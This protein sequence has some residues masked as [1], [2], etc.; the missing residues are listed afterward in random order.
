MRSAPCRFTFTA[1]VAVS[2][3]SF[4]QD[5]ER[6]GNR[7]FPGLFVF[8]RCPRCRPVCQGLQLRQNAPAG[9]QLIQ[10]KAGLAV[11]FLS[12]ADHAHRAWPPTGAPSCSR[13][14]WGAGGPCLMPPPPDRSGTE[15][16]ARE[17]P[18]CGRKCTGA[19]KALE[20]TRQ[21][22]PARMGGPGLR[23]PVGFWPEMRYSSRIGCIDFDVTVFLQT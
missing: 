9:R 19:G 16:P 5:D 3:R 17:A 11:L 20:T 23:N 21:C 7:D 10:V 8:V 22:R 12:G 18:P 13:V 15:S 6:P 4:P 1:G 2:N 14:S